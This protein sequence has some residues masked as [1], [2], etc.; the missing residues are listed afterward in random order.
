MRNNDFNLWFITPKIKYICPWVSQ[1]ALNVIFQ[2]NFWDIQNQGDIRVFGSYCFIG[3]SLWVRMD[4]SK[5]KRSQKAQTSS[6]HLQPGAVKTWL[7]TLRI[8]SGSKYTSA[9]LFVCDV[10]PL[11]SEHFQPSFQNL[12]KAQRSDFGPT[13]DSSPAGKLS[14]QLSAASILQA[15]FSHQMRT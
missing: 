6:L 3:S 12:S 14:L 5:N 15:L 7:K 1:S 2:G 11:L 8:H 9:L 13:G 10:F 4:M